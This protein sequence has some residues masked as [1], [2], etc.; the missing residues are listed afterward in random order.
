MQLQ[1]QF[2]NLS[3]LV[4]FLFKQ[5][6]RAK[7]AVTSRKQAAKPQGAW[8]RERQR[9]G[10]QQSLHISFTLFSIPP[11]TGFSAFFA[12]R[13]HRMNTVSDS[14]VGRFRSAL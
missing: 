12:L 1:Q 11:L 10:Q 2:I 4:A 13:R 8:E 6:E 9:S 5:V 14:I 3:S 7:E